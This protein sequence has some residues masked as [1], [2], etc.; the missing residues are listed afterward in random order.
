MESNRLGIY[1]VGDHATANGGKRSLEIDARRA[2]ALNRTQ[3]LISRSESIGRQA[4]RNF[5]GLQVLTVGLAAITPC[6][7]FLARGDPQDQ[8]LNG[9]Q[10]FFPS[11]AAL[12]AV[13][14]HIF[15]WREDGVRNT[16]LV[17]Q[18][19]SELWQ[20]QT[21]TGDCSSRL[22][23]EQ[24]LDHLVTRID[25]LVLRAVAQWSAEHLATTDAPSAES[26]Q[27]TAASPATASAG[28]E[29]WAL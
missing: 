5:Y 16:R 29:S 28:V 6:L 13:M 15:H 26:R 11:L 4:W 2:V 10:L 25:S 12:C 19:R 9:L 3:E 17:E 8:V 24:A 21:R 23:E 22:D 20:F 27:K 7:I 1:M 18:L 14:S